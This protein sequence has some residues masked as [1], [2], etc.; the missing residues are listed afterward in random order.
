MQ[1]FLSLLTCIYL[2]TS[3]NNSSNHSTDDTEIKNL[4]ADWN[5][6][7]NSKDTAVF[8][9]LFDDSVLFYGVQLDK[10]S[11][12]ESKRSLFDKHPDFYEQ[13]FGDIQI[14]KLGDDGYLSE[15]ILP[16]AQYAT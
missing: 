13:I 11:C 8:S 5:K 15:V 14:E 3:C 10:N 16:A 4:V 2:L 9:N 6:A 7:H 12:I 1:K